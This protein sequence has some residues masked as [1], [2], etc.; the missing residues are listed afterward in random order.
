MRK[1]ISSAVESLNQR[2]LN[3]YKYLSLTSGIVKVEQTTVG[4]WA[5]VVVHTETGHVH[6]Y[7]GRTL[8]QA[9]TNY[10]N[11]LAAAKQWEKKLFKN[12]TPQA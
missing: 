3:N 9:M 1:S 11:E 7:N 4:T 8:V 6:E 10:E 5:R 12:N 2:M